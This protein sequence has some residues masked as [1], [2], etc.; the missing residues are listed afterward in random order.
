VLVDNGTDSLMF[1]DE[2]ALGSPQEDMTSMAA[3]YGLKTVKTKILVNL[4]FGVDSFH[5]VNHFRYL[6]NVSTIIKQGGF[7]GAF[8]LLRETKE[9]Q[10]M[11]EIYLASQPENSIVCSSVTSAING[12]FGNFH[13]E[14]TVYRTNYSQLFINPIMSMYWSFDLDTVASNII[15]L[16]EIMDCKDILELNSVIQTSRK[17][18]FKD[19]EYIGNRPNK[20]IPH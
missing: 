12:D 4:G 11:N 17:K 5:G 8:S 13:H 6:E 7:F 19:G 15:F 14:K 3:I 2:Y 20:I 16:K 10:L 1:G 9:A 18:Y